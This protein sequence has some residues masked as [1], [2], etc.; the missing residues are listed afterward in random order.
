MKLI[1]CIIQ[2]F[3]LQEVVEAIQ[4]FASGMTVSEAK[5][6]G[7]QKGH[8]I[9][10]RGVEY[11][12]AL[13]AKAVIEIAA[14]DNRVDDIIKIVIQTASTGNIGDGKIFVL[15]LDENYH[16]RTGFMDLD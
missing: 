4:A 16:V 3:E 8:T 12:N 11:E 1:K 14:D 5:G 2:P 10:Y 9:I 13:L 15:P 7:R 6:M